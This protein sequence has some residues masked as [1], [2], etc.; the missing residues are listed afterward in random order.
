MINLF[1]EKLQAEG[2]T[3][4]QIAAKTGLSQSVIS[5]LLKGGNCNLETAI[6][7]ADA[8][9][10]SIDEVIG[11]K[12]PTRKIQSNSMLDGANNILS[13]NKL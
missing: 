13:E 3:Q 2:L 12:A 7:F 10:V 5:K 8:F 9:G 1:L 11:R 6:K 4:T